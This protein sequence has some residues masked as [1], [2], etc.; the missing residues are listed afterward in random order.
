MRD[1]GADVRIPPPPAARA[2]DAIAFEI[3][4]I[5]PRA[6]PHA[7]VC[8]STASPTWW[9]SMTYAV[10]AL[11]GPAHMPMTPDTDRT[12]RIASDS[13]RSSTMSAKLAVNRRVRSYAARTSTPR[14]CFTSAAWARR[15]PAVSSRASAESVAVAG[16]RV[17]RARRTSAPSR[18]TRPLLLRELRDLGVASHRILGQGEV[19]TVPAR[20]E[21]RTLRVD[22]VAVADQVE[23]A[24]HVRR[25]PAHYVRQRGH[26]VVGAERVLGDGGT[27]N[28][29]PP[30]E[31]EHALPG[32]S[33]IRGRDEAVVATA[34][35]HCVVVVA[36]HAMPPRTRGAGRRHRV[37]DSITD[38][39]LRQKPLLGN[40]LSDLCRGTAGATGPDWNAT[41]RD[42]NATGR[43][44]GTSGADTVGATRTRRMTRCRGSS[45]RPRVAPP[46][47]SA[48]RTTRRSRP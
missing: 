8:P 35:D 43:D 40:D 32:P 31:H 11:R 22:V 26:R 13:K 27:A 45:G 38:D 17:C 39:P 16:R 46:A 3:A 20:R 28:D 14:S 34:D 21:I 12:P 47:R 33:E 41:G 4:P 19:A 6:K 42:R 1:T 7:P 37:T 2:D 36:G 25:E 18:R 24:H 48:G 5:P 30:F 10:P 44:P 29:R 15:W 9:C 23:I